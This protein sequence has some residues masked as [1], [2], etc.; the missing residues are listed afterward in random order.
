MGEI[1][2][3]KHSYSPIGLPVKPEQG[4]GAGLASTS[5]LNRE[6][7]QESN[8]SVGHLQSSTFYIAALAI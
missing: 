1:H 8:P 6:D 7:D 5:T 4:S 3:K 2:E